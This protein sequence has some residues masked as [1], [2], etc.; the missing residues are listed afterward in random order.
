MRI[1][2]RPQHPTNTCRVTQLTRDY[3]AIGTESEWVS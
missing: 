1:G 2:H 3:T